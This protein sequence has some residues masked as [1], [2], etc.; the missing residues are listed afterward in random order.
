MDAFYERLAVRAATLDEVLSGDF[1]A[2]PGQKGD[3]DL[4][5]R[6]LAAWCRACASGD[7]SLFGQR[8]DRD[9]FAFAPVLARLAAV[10]RTS[11]ALPSWTEDAIW[12]E[13]ALQDTGA[14]ATPLTNSDKND[15]C[16]FEQLFTSLVA[17]ADTRLWSGLDARV[18]DN[19]NEAARASLRLAL[20]RELS[21][22]GTAALYERLP[23]ARH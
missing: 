18:G 11:A 15:P 10:R 19:L 7:W 5:G 16:A 6:R 8:L 14:N 3:A 20:L 2:L 4:A 22:L 1:E 13:A 21:S 9:G 17:Q 12:V 23:Q